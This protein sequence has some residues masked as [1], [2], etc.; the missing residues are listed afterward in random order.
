MGSQEESNGVKLCQW[1]GKWQP[2]MKQIWKCVINVCVLTDAK[3]FSSSSDLNVIAVALEL[4]D[5]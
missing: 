1:K 2:K 3:A 4:F 5:A